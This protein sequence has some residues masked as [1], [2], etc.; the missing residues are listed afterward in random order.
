[1]VACRYGKP[2]CVQLYI[3]LLRYQVEHSK[4]YSIFTFA[5]SAL[6]KRNTWPMLIGFTNK[7]ATAK[8]GTQDREHSFSQYEPT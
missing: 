5:H 6:H 1:M 2:L 3:S 8:V 4:R 7:R